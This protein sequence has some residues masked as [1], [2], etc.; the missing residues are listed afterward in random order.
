VMNELG[1]TDVYL[2]FGRTFGHKPFLMS[3]GPFMGVRRGGQG[4]PKIV[5]F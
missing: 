1:L 5:C 2:T 3:K 4:R